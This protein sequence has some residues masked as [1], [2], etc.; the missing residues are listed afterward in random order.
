M[1]HA[2]LK[3]Y[4]RFQLS[5]LSSENG[6]HDFEKISF[7]IARRRVASNLL[8][9][10][11]PVSSGG[12]QG[13][14]FE[15]YKTYLVGLPID[16][17]TFVLSASEMI[18]VGA[19]TLEKIASL[20]GKVTDDIASICGYGTKPDL[21]VYFCEQNVPVAKRHAWIKRCADKHGV[22]LQIFDGAAISDILTEPDTFWIAE[23]YLGVPSEAF[24]AP[25]V[26]ARYAEMKQRWISEDSTPEHFADFIEIKSGTRLARTDAQVDLER[27]IRKLRTFI[28][29]GFSPRLEQRARYEVCVAELRGRGSLD[30]ALSVLH[31]FF[32]SVTS[33]SVASELSDAAVMMMYV[34]G[35]RE[36]GQTSLSR[37]QALA[38]YNT[39]N[40]L[41]TDAIVSPGGSRDKATLLEAHAMLSPIAAS[42]GGEAPA[43]VLIQ[44]WQLVLDEIK[45]TPLFPV[46]HVGEIFQVLARDFGNDERVQKMAAEVDKIVADQE[47]AATIGE[48]SLKRAAGHLKEGRRIAA[49]SELQRVKSAWLTGETVDGAIFAMV[50]MA[51]IY[52]EMKLNYAARYY[53]AG[54]LLVA[55]YESNDHARSMIG[56]AADVIARSFYAAGEA[57][58][59]VYSV[60]QTMSFHG[61][62]VSDPGNWKKHEYIA[63]LAATA[64]QFRVISQR[65]AP[66]V[67]TLLDSAFQEWPMA[68]EEIEEMKANCERLSPFASESAAEIEKKIADEMGVSPF[69]DLGLV[70]EVEWLAL[71]IHWHIFHGSSHDE[72]IMATAVAATLQVLQADLA[73]V[74]LAIIPSDVEIRLSLADIARPQNESIPSNDKVICDLKMPIRSDSALDVGAALTT[75]AILLLRQ[76]SALPNEALDALTDEKFKQGL[77]DRITSVRPA[78]E[79][80][81]LAEPPALNRDAMEAFVRPTL[82]VAMAPQEYSELAWPIVKGPGYSRERA[83]GM[84]TDRYSYGPAAVA[85]TLPRL[86]A[87]AR[88][89]KVLMEMR[90]SGMRDWMMLNTISS[91]VCG[92]QAQ[93]V[94]GR[95]QSRENLIAMQKWMH[96]R[97]HRPEDESDPQFDLDEFTTELVARQDLIQPLSTLKNWGLVYRQ[98]T[99]DAANVRRFLDVRYA[100][101]EDDIEHADPFPGL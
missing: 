17:N 8:P 44:R 9:A 55:I 21:I 68:P 43:E 10:T 45:Q 97:I 84:L 4:I 74:E 23:Q 31:M 19:S 77:A 51:H 82:S 87:D 49:L 92:W 88:C 78:T 30:P 12:D 46:W 67:C 11:G 15:S 96:E 70:T 34:W 79:L 95:P 2:E 81:A 85:W 39:L 35:A 47:G 6:H 14:D 18:I 13:R 66:Q 41:I 99:P 83:T 80:M 86:L 57:V 38:Y 65:I 89:R 75:V 32:E 42:D 93:R 3:R 5:E 7:E 90:A 59:Y 28:G 56:K 25:T 64:V 36:L 24:P 40:R 100:Y 60:G 58:T 22:E 61:A 98:Q 48:R 26:N 27:W 71:G 62:T 94:L 54:A 50:S 53:A 1:I 52:L 37:A 76:A 72:R 73:D 33:A 91:I 16:G 20:A 69:S 101:S 29:N 63:A